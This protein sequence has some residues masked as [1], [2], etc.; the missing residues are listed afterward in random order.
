MSAD[1]PLIPF[2]YTL[3]SEDDLGIGLGHS[4]KSLHAI[5][6]SHPL[7]QPGIMIFVWL[8]VAGLL[9]I[10]AMY[11][12]ILDGPRASLLAWSAIAG[13]V[14]L[15]VGAAI[16]KQRLW[17][18]IASVSAD[19]LSSL[20]LLIVFAIPTA[21]LLLTLVVSQDL[22]YTTY[23][24][25]LIVGYALLAPSTE[26]LLLY[27]TITLAAWSAC[28]LRCPPGAWVGY[29]LPWMGTVGM[30]MFIHTRV[31][32]ARP[33]VPIKPVSRP[34]N[35]VIDIDLEGP[36]RAALADRDRAMTSSQDLEA[37]LQ[38]LRTTSG[39]Q[40]E[41][42]ELIHDLS[43]LLSQDV[44]LQEVGNTWLE[45]LIA[46]LP[47]QHASIWVMES[48]KQPQLAVSAGLTVNSD[49]TLL[50]QSIRS[51]SIIQ[52]GAHWACPLDLGMQGKGTLLLHGVSAAA[53][54]QIESLLR[55]TSS[56][57]STFLRWQM[58]EAET[59][60]LTQEIHQLQD[61][62]QHLQND[63]TVLESTNREIHEHL[64]HQ[65]EMAQAKLDQHV[66]QSSTNDEQV[67]HWKA[68]AQRWQQ[69]LETAQTEHDTLTQ[70]LDE[71]EKELKALKAAG[72]QT[73]R[74][75]ELEQKLKASETDRSSAEANWD[76]AEKQLEESKS[77]L[78]QAQT[79]AAEAQVEW[80]RETQTVSLLSSALRA[81]TDA[82][83]VYDATGQVLYENDAARVLRG[84]SRNQPGEHPLWKKVISNT[85]FE[86][87]QSWSAD[88]EAGSIHYEV[89]ISPLWQDQANQGFVFTAR[90]KVVPVETQVVPAKTDDLEAGPRFFGALAQ[91]LEPPLSQLIDHAD[92]LLETSTD[93]N[94]RRHA[95]VG[96]LQQGRHVRR[97]LTQAMDYAQL[98][99]GQSPVVL[100][101]ASPWSIIQQALT[102]L[103]PVAEEKGLVLTVEP[104]GPLP[105]SIKTDPDRLLQVIRHII[106]EELRTAISGS[107]VIRVGLEQMKPSQNGQGKLRFDIDSR[108]AQRQPT[109]EVRHFALQFDQTI[110]L[111]QAQALGAEI[112]ST[113]AGQSSLLV[114]VSSAELL[115]L[116]PLDR[117]RIDDSGPLIPEEDTI[118]FGKVLVV[119]DG[120]EAQR[121]TTYQLER[122]GLRSE[123]LADAERAL[124]RVKEDHFDVVLWDA[125]K[126]DK[127]PVQAAHELRTH[128]YQ[129]GIL[130]VGQPDNTWQRDEFL[131]AGGDGLLA[132][133]I[134]TAVWRNTLEGYLTQRTSPIATNIET[135][136]SQYQA[137]R[138]FIHLI[139]TYVAK[140]P[141]HLADMRSSSQVADMARLTRL[142][143]ALVDGGQLYGYPA[144]SETAE[145]LE[146]TILDGHD[147]ITQA[148]LLD[149]LE[150]IVR[151]IEN[152]LKLSRT[153][154][155][156]AMP[157]PLTKAA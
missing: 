146:K 155:Y 145:Q 99:S 133:P 124:E 49:D 37:R 142:T 137:D 81:I 112:R 77:A 97:I 103:L 46:R 21:Q 34:S 111:K 89:T 28:A 94:I 56:I 54:H 12:V 39:S 44:T 70:M 118:F 8:L 2:N 141:S 147:A 130:A 14:T 57:L 136:L 98:Q 101:P 109:N 52:N 45:K 43:H 82:V 55:T 151:K 148:S 30:A 29:V 119:V 107:I 10:T 149:Q 132:R 15:L 156:L 126:Q 116:I 87:K 41:Q 1:R 47:A 65:Y 85:A 27:V 140:L 134:V 122:I 79:E 144:L 72:N 5:A 58:A 139:R 131:Q 135:M 36:L 102:Q 129:G 80:E 16:I 121:V 150:Q 9:A 19:Q 60:S 76:A 7:L 104:G 61:R 26:S 96:I 115:N 125:T 20:L 73:N 127:T 66:A 93:Q 153:S 38:Q 31:M 18:K 91:T 62:S 95:L 78:R 51:S 33:V 120:Q 100:A 74:V 157:G 59:D 110:L 32:S 92:G 83:V 152:G 106:G 3:P 22:S 69:L 6:L 25:L 154:G 71:T 53:T 64:R 84:N 24:L 108:Q 11:H 90:P 143:H 128:H 40:I 50:N 88:Y 86:K 13:A 17:T 113:G 117:L 63:L 68:E 23:A 35:S 75:K 105:A 4:E 48:S 123:V 42:L 114:P 67:A 138:E